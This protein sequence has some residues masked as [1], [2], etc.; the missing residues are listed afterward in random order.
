MEGRT[1]RRKGGSKKNA[2]CIMYMCQLPTR[3]VIM[4]CCED[5]AIKRKTYRK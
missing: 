4:M 1:K 5:V 3:H 2:R